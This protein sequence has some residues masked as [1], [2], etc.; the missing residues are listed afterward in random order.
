M[1]GEW[2]AKQA[3]VTELYATRGTSPD[4]VA[5]AAL[6]AVARGRTLVPTPRYQVVPPWLVKRAAPATGSALSA[7]LVRRLSALGT[8]SPG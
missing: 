3:G 7:L 8:N 6:S 5:K 4:V 2:V 1:R